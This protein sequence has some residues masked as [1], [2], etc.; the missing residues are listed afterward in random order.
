MPK[1]TKYP[2]LRVHTRRG[3]NGQVWTSWYYDMRAAGLPDVALG[4]DYAAALVRWAELHE[5]T[6]KNRG[7]LQEAFDEWRNEV[8][9]TYEDDET[10]KGYRLSLNKI[11]AWCGQ[12]AWH[13][14]T[15]PILKQ[16]LKKRTAK[17]SANKEVTLLGLIWN[18]ARGEGL[19][20]LP[21]PAAGL[22]K[23]RWKNKEHARD[24]EVTDEHFDAL[25]LHAEPLLRDA[26]DL[27]TATGLR[28][29]DVVALQ[30]TDQRG[31]ILS[32]KARKRG[33][34]AEFDLTQ[35][36][37]LPALLERRRTHKALH[38]QL[39]TTP[40]GR[41]VTLRMLQGAFNRA[42]AA[43]AL[44]CPSVKKV[45]LRDMRKRASKLAGSLDAA[46]KLLQHGDKATTAKHY[47]VGERLKPVR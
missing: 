11:E 41:Q 18:W 46:S 17:R 34:K 20:K 35:S 19:T 24:V 32:I 12:M 45:W 4:S 13:E 1:V 26:M 6:P 39:L 37:I 8:L 21:W 27:S 31:N 25:Y 15:L 33:K 22:A 5:G 28:V 44:D 43:A 16:Y 30:I 42:R 36:A 40:T 23:S 14:I 2:R 29:K 9:P 38:F 3:A 47:P 7:R 10:R